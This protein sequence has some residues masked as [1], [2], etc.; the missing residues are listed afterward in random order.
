MTEEIYQKLPENF[1]LTGTKT[2]NKTGQETLLINA[3]Y[4]VYD[5]KRNAPLQEKNFAALQSLVGMARTLRSE[6]GITPDKKLR[7]LIR[8]GAEL[9]KPF[10]EN[11]GLIKLLA[12]AGELQIEAAGG[13]SNRPSGSI[14]LAG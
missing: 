3:Q 4:P 11:E 13:S 5:E 10:R 1:R 9:E 12:G 14:G 2:Q 8:S 6:C 7:L